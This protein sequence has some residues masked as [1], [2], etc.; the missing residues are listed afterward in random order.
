MVKT[1]KKSPYDVGAAI[2]LDGEKEYKQAVANIGASMKTLN[3]EMKLAKSENDGAESSMKSL[4]EQY[5]LQK[6]IVAQNEEK[7][8]VLSGALEDAK[9]KYGENSRQAKKWSD[10]LINAKTALNK[11]RAE[12]E[13]LGEQK[14]AITHISN[15]LKEF[16]EKA[17]DVRD[18]L[19]KVASVG[20]KVGSMSLKATTTAVKG[21]GVAAGAAATGITAVATGMVTLANN[22]AEAGKEIS[23]MA[24]RTG[25]STKAYQE[26]DYIAKQA[27]TTMDTLQGGIT[28]LAEKM[29]DA[30]KGEGEA[31]EI[32]K[33]LGINVTDSNG[34]L[35]NQQA[36]FEETVKSLQ[37]VEDATKRQA[38]ATKLMSTTGEELLPL[39]NGEIGSIEELKKAAGDLGLI[40]SE[41][42]IN[43]SIEFEKSLNNLQSVLTGVKNNMSAEFLPGLTNIMDGITGIFTGDENAVDTINKGVEDISDAFG[44]LTPQI[45]VILQAVVNS[46]SELAP[47]IIEVLS[48]GLGETIDPLVSSASSILSTLVTALIDNIDTIVDAAIIIIESLST[49]LL[50]EENLEKVIGAAVDLII[51]LTTALADNIDLVINA[52]LVIVDS[53]IAGLTSDENMPKLVDGALDLVIGLTAGLIGAV[54]ELLKGAGKLIEALVNALINYDWL[55]IG[56]RIWAKI[57]AAWSGKEAE[58]EN[59]I[60]VHGSHASGL[61]SVPFDG[62]IAELHAAER[63]LTAS[64][65]QAYN[66]GEYI[67]NEA[68]RRQLES[69]QHQN[70]AEMYALL[71]EMRNIAA[72]LRGGIGVDINNTRDVK[73]MVSGNA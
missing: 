6:D 22:T 64:E 12:L 14:K 69:S 23:V 53:L 58:V 16:K 2:Y 11:S 54:P 3:A 57:K 30:A 63:V 42:A 70:S 9:E 36:V 19:E 52:A 4:R 13:Q 32:F 26:W 8:R 72:I 39:L 67:S 34:K 40:M 45:S 55:S 48:S 24:E 20:K 28:D 66:R 31:A 38:L 25:L 71:E 60:R 65:A 49:S 17:E 33:Q 5:E 37:K 15:S 35:K 46:I 73:R 29:D 44:E 1:G 21:L 27:G 56:S 41:E 62:Y 59:D 7:I 51:Q 47:Q 43:A 18:K 50:D 61:Y 68:L 10:E